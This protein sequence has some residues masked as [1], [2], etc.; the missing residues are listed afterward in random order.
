MKYHILP[1][2]NPRNRDK[3]GTDE[4]W[5]S[6]HEMNRKTVSAI[7]SMCKK[8]KE[9][10][11]EPLY[12]YD[13]RS[14]RNLMIKLKDGDELILH[15]EGQPFV[16]GLDEPSPDYDL[17]AYRLAEIL[18]GYGFPKK[19]I[20][21][22]LLACH[23]GSAW[24]EREKG[25]NLNFARDLSRTLYSV[26]G[27]TQPKVTGYTGFIV[28]KENNGK[29]SVSAELDT[30]VKGKRPAH[31]SLDA[32]KMVYQEG[33]PIMTECCNTPLADISNVAYGWA[34]K[35]IQEAHRGNLKTLRLEQQ[36]FHLSMMEVRECSDS[37][38]SVQ[39]DTT[40]Q[41]ANSESN[42]NPR[43]S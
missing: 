39:S 19:E 15:G 21:I 34:D 29:Y 16:I 10:Y 43:L 11:K 27:Y 7:G 5:R 32:A 18:N 33:K 28:D 38:C 26:F 6:A 17:N 9:V 37:P 24:E 30:S 1:M 36:R 20:N 13:E 31:R 40:S 2:E 8:D 14:M 3:K 41:D 42:D 12:L 25:I 23:S 22:K 4:V 35:Y